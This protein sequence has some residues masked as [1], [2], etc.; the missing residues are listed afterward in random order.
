MKR[1]LRATIAVTGLGADHGTTGVAVLRALAEDA[2]RDERR[3]GLACGP[4]DE[5]IY[6]AEV[7]DAFVLPAPI[8][9][10]AF[11]K[12]LRELD[13]RVDLD[14]LLPTL[15]RDIAALAPRQLEL[16]A[17]GIATLLPT[18]SQL[19]LLD[20]VA[21]G[22]LAEQSRIDV[23]KTVI[24]ESARQLG[25][26]HEQLS[27]PIVLRAHDVSVEAFS[28]DELCIAYQRVA[29]AGLPAIARERARGEEVHVVGLGDGE[30]R[31]VGAVAAKYLQNAGPHSWVMTTLSA[32]AAIAAATRWASATRWRGPFELSMELV[33]G[34][35]LLC[36]A[37]AH[38]PAWIHMATSAG[39]NL[40][41]AAAQLALGRE[42]ACAVDYPVGMVLVRG[43]TD[44][45]V[46][47]REVN[48]AS[49]LGEVV[50]HRTARPVKVG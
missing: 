43:A 25:R 42:P 46:S 2:P 14:V 8:E 28:H 24:V 23:P 38:F 20:P 27:Y 4:L 33:R 19:E 10:N 32:P 35:A 37:R 45:V 13:A 40:P 5:G 7:D 49:A 44:R 17:M 34:R 11:M 21:L 50:R 1:T 6:A 12:R 47:A 26:L 41:R 18:P 36:R 48:E 39:V 22:R 15:S 29:T 16:R 3:I 30:G 31:L 9:T